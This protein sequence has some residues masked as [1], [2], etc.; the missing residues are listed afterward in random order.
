MIQLLIRGTIF[1]S[2][3]PMLQSNDER[4]ILF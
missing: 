2:N 4:I 1:L 3:V